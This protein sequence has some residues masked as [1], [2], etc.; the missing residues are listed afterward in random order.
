MAI[1]DQME[2]ALSSPAPRVDPVSGNEVPPGSLPV[3]VRDDIDVKLSEGEYVVPA[4]VLRFHGV[5]FFEDLRAE[6]KMGLAGM[7]AT[8]RIGGEPVGDAP[9]DPAAMDPAAMG[10][11]EE[12]IA[13]LEEAMGGGGI[14]AT[15][16]AKG[17]LMDKVAFTAMNDPLVN[18]RIN[19]KGMAVGFAEGGMTQSLYSDPTRIDSLIDKVMNAAQNNPSLLGELSKRGVTVN[20]TK[21]DMKPAEMQQAN[22]QPVG[23]AHGGLTHGDDATPVGFSTDMGTGVGKPSADTNFNPFQY[24]LGYSSFGPT[25]PAG[26]VPAPVTP[27]PVAPTGLGAPQIFY[28]I[29]GNPH[30]SQAAADA[31]NAVIRGQGGDKDKP[32]EPEADPNAWMGKYDYSDPDVLA[33]KT[34]EILNK[35][36]GIISSTIGNAPFGQAFQAAQ[37]TEYQANIDLLKGTISAEK[38]AELVAAA[39]KYKDARFGETP[40]GLAAF[41]LKNDLTDDARASLVADDPDHWSNKATTTPKKTDPVSSGTPQSS[42]ADATATQAA[43]DAARARSAETDKDESGKAADAE[44]QRTQKAISKASKSLDKSTKGGTSTVRKDAGI[45]FREKEGGGYSGGFNKGGLMKKK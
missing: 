36:Q 16:L 30:A 12:D 17:G 2:M 7:D 8:G 28:D 21:A 6:A 14:P 25:V 20:T 43:A 1:N 15:A 5:K 23:L 44:R 34:L 38:H 13:M 11:S 35:K 4:D 9:M 32:D 42:A 31:A 19:S 10:I 37:F 26:S 27:A 29:N 33:S 3:E 22:T 24:G 18:E 45:T 41:F 40:S 39:E